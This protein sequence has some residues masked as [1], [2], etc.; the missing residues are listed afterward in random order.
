MAF[1][2]FYFPVDAVQGRGCGTGVRVRHVIELDC[3]LHHVH[4][5]R[6]RRATRSAV[7]YLGC[8]IAAMRAGSLDAGQAGAYR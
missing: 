1:K 2:K 7:G 6:L 4:L 5:S 8:R 3:R